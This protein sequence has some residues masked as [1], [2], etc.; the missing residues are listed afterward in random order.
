MTPL[1]AVVED[2]WRIRELIACELEDLG[3]EVLRCREGGEL[4]TDSRLDQVEIVLLDWV[5]PGLDGKGTLRVLNNKAFQA[6]VVVVTS[7]SDPGV[8]EAAQR[9]GAAAILLKTEVVDRLPEL[10]NRAHSYGGDPDQWE[11]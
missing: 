1:V 2:N 10:L 5:M 9:E 11:H 3:A 7:L 8:Q 6:P 4:L